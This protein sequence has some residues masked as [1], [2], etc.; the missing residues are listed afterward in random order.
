M[1]ELTP[2]ELCTLRLDAQWLHRRAGP[3]SLVEAVQAVVGIQAQSTPAMMLALR[4]RV[5]ELE[6]E[7]VERAIAESRT[8]ARTWTMRGTLHLQAAAD[9]RWLVGLLGPVFM[10]QGKGRRLQLGLDEDTVERGIRAI[11][12]ILSPGEVVTR[13]VIVERLNARGFSL[14]RKTQAPIH[15][16]GQAALAGVIL[17][18]PEAAGGKSTNV[19]ADGWVA[20]GEPLARDAALAGLARRYVSGYG[21]VDVADFAAW[22]GLSMTDARRGWQAALAEGAWAE[23]SVEG[24]ALWLDAAALQRLRPGHEP[25]VR[26]LPAFDACVLGYK[27]RDQLVAPERQ[28]EV[29]HG[30]Q[31]VPVVMVDGLAVGVWR[32]E[33]RGRKL[34][35]DVHAFDG[36]DPA[37]QQMIWAEADDIGR[38]WGL[39][40]SVEIG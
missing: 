7:A 10:A 20:P 39:P 23:V 5:R 33:R 19:L 3:E 22:S 4:A 8:L 16:I 17:V 32:Y 37:D 1:Q 25:S 18:G 38:L 15:L 26:L 31:T 14:D 34:H 6:V 35:I 13:D 36:F 24:R 9:F 2:Q 27:N 40:V 11:G 29:Y 12:E 30:G 21:P 28:P